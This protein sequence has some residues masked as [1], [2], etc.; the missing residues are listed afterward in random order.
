MKRILI[1]GA[2]GFVGSNLS[3]H[4]HDLGYELVLVDSLEY[5]GDKRRLNE[6]I[7]NKLIIDNLM[8]M[9]SM[10]YVSNV[11]VI[12]HLAGISS[13]PLNEKDPVASIRNNYMSTVNLYEAGVNYRVNQFYFAST[14]AVY[15]NNK[16][17]PF[18]E[19]MPTNPDLFYSYSKKLTEDYL[20]IRSSKLDGINTTV[21]RFFNVFGSGQNTL[22]L[23]P[24]L[25]GYLMD[26]LLRK[27]PVV[28]YNNTD[29]K[30]DYIHV[31]DIFE[32][33][34]KMLELRSMKGEKY[35][36]FNLCSGNSYSVPQIVRILEDVCGDKLEINFGKPVEIWS[37]HS[38]IFDKISHG[39]VER[40]VFKES[41][42]SNKKLV[43]YLGIDFQFIDMR[44]GLKEMYKQ[45][46]REQ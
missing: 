1:T 16:S 44:R 46:L 9:N 11:D 37:R 24:P 21:L 43:E 23:N 25:T 7:R 34:L 31:K 39:R 8:S 2:A 4:L 6:E 35:E 45:G 14:S 13:L 20:K 5:G 40:E 32:I 41:I 33:V 3:N 17:H 22:R 10:N 36:T 29:I 18:N 28:L 38:A 42:G 15:E 27:E 19:E 12:I 30:R 26:K